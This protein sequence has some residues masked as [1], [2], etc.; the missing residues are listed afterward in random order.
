MDA[1]TK[2]WAG[3]TSGRRWKRE[4][5]D[6]GI[7]GFVR[8]WETKYGAN[9]W[10]THAHFLLFV[11]ESA[12]EL[13]HTLDGAAIDAP[14]IFAGI[15]SR[16]A[17][18]VVRAGFAA[19]L[20]VAQDFHEVVDVD[21]SALGD[22]L[23]KQAAPGAPKPADRMA[24]EMSAHGS[25]GQRYYQSGYETR[26]LLDWASEGDDTAQLLW[27]EYELAMQGRRTIAWAR[28]LRD[29]LGLTAERTDEEIAAEDLGTQ[30]DVLID[31]RS[32]SRAVKRVR[33]FRGRLLHT[34]AEGGP[35]AALD[36]LAHLG[37]D[38]WAVAPPG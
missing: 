6:Y 16:W 24:W 12:A 3:V 13:T 25:K 38:A 20:P 4:R 30:D 27:M 34:Y 37:V 22:Y 26:W 7:R 28:G 32:W 14:T 29:E 18:A 36:Y 1:V 9:G 19:P 11:D 21:A 8:V 5:A 10:H 2:G 35:A 17:S 33:G 23:S 15:F 31:G